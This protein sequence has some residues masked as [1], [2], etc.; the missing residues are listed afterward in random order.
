MAIGS[1]T[2]GLPF[3]YSN[4][5]AHIHIFTYEVWTLLRVLGNI[6]THS[7]YDLPWSLHRF[8]PFVIGSAYHDVHHTRRRGNYALIFTWW[9]VLLK[10]D[11]DGLPPED[12]SVKKKI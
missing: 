11:F 8:L 3:V 6:D 2:I 5:V 10:T 1:V 7:G 12:Y 9:D 4:F